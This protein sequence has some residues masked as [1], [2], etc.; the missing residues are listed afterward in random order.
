MA[1]KIKIDK[2]KVD[3]VTIKKGT[4]GDHLLDLYFEEIGKDLFHLFESDGTKIPTAPSDLQNG[5]NFTFVHKGL[6]WTVTGF[7]ISEHKGHAT[8]GW[9]VPGDPGI[10]DGDPESGTFQAQAGPSVP[11]DKPASA[12]AKA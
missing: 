6:V 7:D 11:V 2:I 5:N 8:G 3:G 1:K 4:V 10:S 9:S 12:S